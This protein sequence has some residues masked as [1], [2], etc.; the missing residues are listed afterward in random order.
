MKLLV[1]QE[2]DWLTRGPHVQHHLFERL[3]RNP[4]LHI[5]ILDYDI[6]KL[7]HSTSIFVKRQEFLDIHRTIKDSNIKIIR[8][9]NLLVP[10]IRRISAL[11]TNFFEI[12]RI[13]KHQRPDVIVGYSITNGLI[14]LFFAKIMGIPYIL[15]YIDILH[16]LVPITYA[17]W[18]ARIISRFSF[19]LA[20]K[21][22]VF[23]SFHRDFVIHEG[24]LPDRIELIPNGISLENIS[25]D[26]HKTREIKEKFSITQNDFVI[27]FMGYL[28]DFAGLIEIVDYYN[29]LVKL[30][31]L[32]LKFLILGGGGIQDELTRHVKEIGA[33]WVIMAG[34]VPYFEVNN[35]IAISDLCLLSFKINDV[36][37]EITPI[38]IIE[39]MAMSK[40]VL[41]NSLPGVVKEIGPNHGVIFSKNQRDLIKK[42]GELANNREQLVP[43]GIQ[44]YEYVKNKYNWPVIIHQFKEIIRNVLRS[45][46]KN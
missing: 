6:D 4:M 36:T 13:V 3:S 38:K 5:L 40:P 39:Y 19:K 14:G 29:N 25:P 35:Y 41:S 34:K 20:D 22:L 1:L 37:K 18:I 15:H 27:F 23:T 28:Y 8:T 12:L 2:T 33:D 43:I 45:K 11:F 44:G 17:Q 42:I 10:F 16:K 9:S 31:K 24:G 7:Q 46:L 26:A 21:I 30:G 32:P